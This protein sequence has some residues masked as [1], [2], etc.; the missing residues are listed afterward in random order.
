MTE[1]SA[2]TPTYLILGASGGIGSEVCRRLAK[3]GARIALAAR[4]TGPLNDLAASLGDIET[5]T[6]EC[7]ATDF[8]HVERVFSDAKERF[9]RIDGVANLVGSILLKPA[10]LTTPA[11]W[12]ETI[13]LN[14]TSAFGVV[15]AAGKHMRSNGESGGSV[16]L[17]STCAARI[18]LSNH[19]AIAAAK[20]GVI[21]L[22][23]AAAATYSTSGLRVNCVA[24]GLI[25]TP[26]SEKIT[27]NDAA[28]QASVAMHPLGRI[29]TPA[30]VAPVIAWLLSPESGF[31]TGQTIGVDG[32]LAT[33]KTRR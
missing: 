7:D 33:V 28:L 22:A 5:E 25:D 8:A 17:A 1:E 2:R 27:S 31:V 12:S 4:R 10:H 14:L 23:Q 26:L 29:G 9:G 18:G 20:A 11:E 24:P 6:Y 13:G 3:Q 15:R 30:D 21:G 19:E 32:G 16:V